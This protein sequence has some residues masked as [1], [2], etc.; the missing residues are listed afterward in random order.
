[1]IKV[2]KK[3]YITDKMLILIYLIMIAYFAMTVHFSLRNF[4][5]EFDRFIL[6]NQFFPV[7]Y[8]QT[9]IANLTI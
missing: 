6:P 9:L 7:L 8:N 2:K 1:M 5:I 3:L 4:R